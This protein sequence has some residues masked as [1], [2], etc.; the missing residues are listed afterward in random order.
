MLTFSPSCPLYS[1]G[2]AEGA[3]GALALPVP[4]NPVQ[5]RQD[6]YRDG[7]YVGDGGV[8]VN[9][10]AVGDAINSFGAS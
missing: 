3:C 5:H 6:L 4:R 1:V 8:A 10:H 9:D 7:E 2:R